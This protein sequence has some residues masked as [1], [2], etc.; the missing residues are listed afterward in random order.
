LSSARVVK[1]KVNSLFLTGVVHI[2]ILKYK[3]TK[4]KILEVNGRR[5]I[6]MANRKW[7]QDVLHWKP[8]T[9]AIT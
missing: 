9:D 6:R 5:Q 3:E 8:Q 2:F 1:C 7:A 4:K